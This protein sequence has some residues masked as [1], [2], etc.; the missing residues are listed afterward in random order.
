MLRCGWSAA[1]FVMEW[2]VR[3]CGGVGG[4]LRKYNVVG[5]AVRE[6]YVLEG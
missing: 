6:S 2:T 1:H 3:G 4:A 5:P